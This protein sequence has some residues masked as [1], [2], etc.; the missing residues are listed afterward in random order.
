M[1][2]VDEHGALG[3]G[4]R[5][6]L[7]CLNGFYAFESA[8]HVF[9]TARSGD[10]IDLNAWNSD[11]LW[12]FEYGDLAEGALFFAEDA[13]GNQCKHVCFFDAETGEFTEF[14]DDLEA[15]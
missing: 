5:T 8:L 14:S 13:F 9:S 11:V 2:K 15:Y 4:L 1:P 7:R 10:E 12:R 6:L 3:E